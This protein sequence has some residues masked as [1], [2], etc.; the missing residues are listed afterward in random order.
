MEYSHGAE[1]RK[2]KIQAP[3][4][5]VAQ[6][7]KQANVNLANR[8][9]GFVAVQS[10]LL[11]SAVPVFVCGCFTEFKQHWLKNRVPA[12]RMPRTVKRAVWAP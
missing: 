10:N 9:S 4:R 8:V 6:P 11:R 12:V 1:I 7:V 2:R 5:L 3:L